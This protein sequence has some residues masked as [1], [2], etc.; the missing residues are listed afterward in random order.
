MYYTINFISENKVKYKSD[1]LM[2]IIIG[3]MMKMQWNYFNLRLVNRR[4]VLLGGLAVPIPL[5]SGDALSMVSGDKLPEEISSMLCRRS[6]DD[7]EDLL[8]SSTVSWGETGSKVLSSC[9]DCESNWD[10]A[11]IKKIHNLKN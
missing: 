9:N 4:S 11:M 7:D 1:N 10:S 8:S 6:W 2:L 5:S 3:F